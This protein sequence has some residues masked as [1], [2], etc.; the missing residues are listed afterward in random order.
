M[1]AHIMMIQL[2]QD[3]LGFSSSGDFM[4]NECSGY[5]TVSNKSRLSM[6]NAE[7]YMNARVS[8]TSLTYYG[9]C[10]RNGNYTVSLHFA[11]IMFT[12]DQTFKSLGKR[13]FDIYIQGELVKKDFNIAE[14]AGGVCKVVTKSFP[15]IVTDTTLE[16]HLYW[17]GKG[18]TSLPYR[19]VYDPLISAISAKS[20]GLYLSISS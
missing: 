16:I 19:S 13:V 12:G 11:E 7:L 2:L 9:F 14:E 5:Y 10:L 4:D 17:A 8:P 6:T 3:H 20:G 18:T 15:T 1:E